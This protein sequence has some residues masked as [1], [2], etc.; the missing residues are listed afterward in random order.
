MENVK[1][2]AGIVAAVLSIAS[3]IYTWI[4]A[5]SRQNET[6]IRK[7]EEKLVEHDRR[8]QSVESELDHL[9]NKDEIT[10][11]RLAISEVSGRLGRMEESNAGLV[12]GVRRIEDYLLKKDDK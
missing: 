7:Q 5:R 2:W 3:L 9:P 4:T 8:I 10:G 6:Q 11:L 12:R 1:A